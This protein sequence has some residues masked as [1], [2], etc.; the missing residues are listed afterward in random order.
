MASTLTQLDALFKDFYIDGVAQTVNQEVDVIRL[1]QKGNLN[2][3]GRRAL[4]KVHTGDTDGVGFALENGALP[5]AGSTTYAELDIRAKYLYA[6]LRATGPA[7]KQGRK[8]AN[9]GAMLDVVDSEVTKKIEQFMR[10]ANRAAVSGGRVVGF[11]NQKQTGTSWQFAGDHA[12]LTAARAAKGSD[13]TLQFIRMDTLAVTASPT[14]SAATAPTS[15]A[16]ALLTTSSVATG[17]VPNGTALA[18]KISDADASLDYLDSEYTGIYGNLA[19]PTHFTVDR[20]TA[21]GGVNAKLQSQGFTMATATTDAELALTIARMNFVHGQI[22]KEYGKLID[23]YWISPE[24]HAQY[25]SLVTVN[26]ASFFNQSKQASGNADPGVKGMEVGLH[27]IPIEVSQHVDQG[28]IVFMN[29]DTWKLAE[30]DPPEW[31][32]FD[33]STWD[34]VSGVDAYEARYEWYMN[35]YCESPNANAVLCGIDPA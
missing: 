3:A 5:T 31:A 21:T 11:I 8:Q 17:A 30:V 20:T 35:L 26:S 2:W 1:F 23:R 32:D 14:F 13:V 28:L 29:T 24:D 15:S 10:S 16:M 27:G 9:G 4:K 18:V 7:I 6:V 34:R 33:G 19:E 25:L 22:R 12:K